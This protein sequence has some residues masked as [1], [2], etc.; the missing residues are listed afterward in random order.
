MQF[1]YVN[2]VKIA[3]T[4]TFHSFHF[5]LAY[6]FLWLF[7][8][9]CQQEPNVGHNFWSH[10]HFFHMIIHFFLSAKQQYQ[11]SI[12]WWNRWYKSDLLG[13]HDQNR[14]IHLEKN[15][16]K[17][18]FFWRNL[19]LNA[20]VCVWVSTLLWNHSKHDLCH[21]WCCSYWRLSVDLSMPRH[22]KS[23]LFK[24]GISTSSSILKNKHK[25]KM[26]TAAIA[27]TAATLA[28]IH[29]MSNS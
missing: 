27:T 3:H 2:I 9:R 15:T 10:V 17:R 1:D 26:G 24:G 14:L 4:S 20:C 22:T 12:E 25:E 11:T 5:F 23:N 18:N 16:D 21:W 19:K 7:C 8:H 13:G 29:E 6:V 28:A